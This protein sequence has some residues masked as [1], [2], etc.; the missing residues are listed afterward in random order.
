MKPLLLFLGFTLL[1]SCTSVSKEKLNLL[2]GYW[3]IE[4]VEFPN[5]GQKEYRMSTDIDFIQLEGLKGFRK[6]M[7]PRFDGNFE[8][9]DDAE[10]F[11]INIHEGSFNIGYKNNLSEWQETITAL[12]KDNFSMQNEDGILYHYKRFEPISITP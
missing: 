4:R 9:S 1:L 11:Q 10:P 6:K 8:T 12:S 2:N 7:K 5:G 3:E